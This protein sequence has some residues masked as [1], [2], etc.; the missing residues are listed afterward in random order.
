MVKNI[1]LIFLALCVG[2]CASSSKRADNFGKKIVQRVQEKK[3][4]N[5]LTILYLRDDSL[6][7][8]N[9]NLM[10]ESGAADD[11]DTKDGVAA[12]TAGLLEKGTQQRTA[13][14]IAEE[15][16][17]LG[18]GFKVEV[19]EDHSIFSAQTL[20]P[21]GVQLMD[22][23]TD[24]ILNPTFQEDEFRRLR[25]S[26]VASA[27]KAV[28]NPS[29]FAGLAWEKFVFEGHPYSKVNYGTVDSLNRIQRRDIN[30]HYLVYFRPNRSYLAVVGRWDKDFQKGLEER[31]SQWEPFESEKEEK[32]TVAAI[33][34]KRIRV[35]HQPDAVQS[36]V[37]LGH[38]SIPRTH[39]DYQTMQVAST[40]LG[41]AFESRLM[42]RIRK[43]LG[44]TYGVRSSLSSHEG[45]GVFQVSL[46]TRTEATAQ[47]LDEIQKVV[48]KA[49]Q[50]GFTEEELKSTKGYLRGAFPRTIEEPENLARWLINLRRLGLS[51]SEVTDYLGRLDRL[52]L[53]KLNEV[54]KRH[55]SPTNFK[56]LVYG[57]RDQLQKLIK[58]PGVEW[59]SQQG[60]L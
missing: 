20:S 42:Q 40:I 11:P 23:F 50:E 32:G 10:V 29:H 26:Y 19:K 7:Y 43:E 30:K 6:P 25:Q 34:G 38:P 4:K 45:L 3:L 9:I 47:V 17:A 60:A 58:D 51:D 14:Q 57:R 27:R 2:A 41:G 33:Q 36:Q 12:L 1:C 39:E 5:G 54:F 46:S 48:S 31:L 52:K 15:F 35:I 59:V 49:V 37:F 53:D 18:T 28:D 55:V 8:V 56:V 13:V 22:L 16:G 24:I 21:K 44:L